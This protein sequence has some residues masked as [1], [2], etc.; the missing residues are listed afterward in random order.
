[1]SLGGKATSGMT[2]RASLRMLQTAIK[3]FL[4]QTKILSKHRA[5]VVAQMVLDFWSAVALLLHDEWSNPRKTLLCK[6]VGVYALMGIGAGRWR[7]SQSARAVELPGAC[8]PLL[9]RGH[10]MHVDRSHDD[11]ADRRDRPA[12]CAS[13]K[14]SW[15]SPLTYGFITRVCRIESTIRYVKQ[16]FW[17][18]I[19]FRF[20]GRSQPAG[21][22]TDREGQ[23]SGPR[24]TREVHYGRL[25]RTNKPR[26]A[27]GTHRRSGQLQQ[28]HQR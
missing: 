14:S 25:R 5:E 13:T 8:L 23:S 9:W 7:M 26:N 11:G 19:Q 12:S 22:A 24:H 1:M 18:G 3:R 2:R 28:W 4:A 27:Q 6:G 17:P 20:V 16:N 10:R 15:S 21:A